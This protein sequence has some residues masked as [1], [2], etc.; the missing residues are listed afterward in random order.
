MEALR[1]LALA[2]AGCVAI[3][4]LLGIGGFGKGGEVNRKYGNKLMRM[5]II[6]QAVAVALILLLIYLRG[7]G[8]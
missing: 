7:Q 3:V 5:R 6:L 4:L 1:I 8:G 2:A